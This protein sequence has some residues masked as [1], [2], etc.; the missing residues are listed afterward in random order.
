M[1]DLIT[2]LLDYLRGQVDGIADTAASGFVETI[3]RDYSNRRGYD[4]GFLGSGDFR[5]PMPT[6]AGAADGSEGA[7]LPYHHF[8]VLMNPERRLARFT[9]VN[10]HGRLLQRIR[11]K[12]CLLYPSPSPRD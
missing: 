12:D 11:R 7:E 3:D 10:I 5:V 6:V 1:A 9:A 2:H 8:T 4:T